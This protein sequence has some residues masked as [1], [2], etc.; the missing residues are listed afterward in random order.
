[1][2]RDNSDPE[3]T[4]IVARLGPVLQ[5]LKITSTLSREQLKE[6]VLSAVKSLS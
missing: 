2:T 5:E 4:V 6:A 1:V 3:S